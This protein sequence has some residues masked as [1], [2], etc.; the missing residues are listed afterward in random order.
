MNEEELGAA[1][2]TLEPTVR[3]RQRIDR[4][5]EAWLEAGDTPLAAEWLGLFRVAPLPAFGLVAVS[6][7]SIVMATPLLWVARALL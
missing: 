3:Q 5:V 7:V 1:W 2:A 6:A 4:R